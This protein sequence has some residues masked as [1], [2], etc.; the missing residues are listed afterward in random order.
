VTDASKIYLFA[1]FAH[2]NT[3]ESFNFRSSLLGTRPFTDTTGM[4][5]DIGGRSFFQH[6][7]YLTQC[8]SAT[9]L[10]C[11][12]IRPGYQHLLS[13]LDLPGR[14]YAAIR[15]KNDQEYGTMGYKGKTAAG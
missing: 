8:P 1:N 10:S 13:Q 15:R 12:A 4:V 11:R 5:H 6:P 3:D 9:R 7:Y 14:I 2:F